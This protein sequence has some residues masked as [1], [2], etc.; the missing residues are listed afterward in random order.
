MDGWTNRKKERKE[1]KRKI[2]KEKE[3]RKKKRKE[4]GQKER[5]KN[6]VFVDDMILHI[7]N[8]KESFFFFFGLF[9][10]FRAS[11]AAYGGFQARDQIGAVA[12]SLRQSHSNAG[13]KLHLRPTPQL[14]ASQIPYPLSKARDQ[15]QNLMDASQVR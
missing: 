13:S 6:C 2:E 11:P 9:F 5:S 12:A 4:T 8:P 15:T 14:T 10:V 3:K 7:E 1:R